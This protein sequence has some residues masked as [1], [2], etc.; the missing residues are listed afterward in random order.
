MDTLLEFLLATYYV[1]L[2]ENRIWSDVLIFLCSVFIC[3]V[4]E[5]KLALLVGLQ[6]VSSKEGG[7]GEGGGGE[8]SDKI[9]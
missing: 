5:P 1:S 6:L 8:L 4:F 3:F 9:L 2:N 7:E